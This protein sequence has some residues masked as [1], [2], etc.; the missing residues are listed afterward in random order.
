MI[1]SPPAL[2]P[3]PWS[4][5]SFLRTGAISATTLAIAGANAPLRAAVR[6]QRVRSILFANAWHCINI[7]D[8][9][10]T[11]GLLHLLETFL[12]D[13][14]VTLWPVP[15]TRPGHRRELDPAVRRMLLAGYPQLTILEAGDA[16]GKGPATRPDLVAAMRESDLFIVGSGGMHEAPLDVWRATTNKPF[17][18][19]GVTFGKISGTRAAALAKA[20][21]I[22]CRDSV[23]LANIQQAGITGPHVGFGPDTTFALHLRDEA[24]AERFL[25][26]AG[27]ANKKF[28]CVIPRHRFSPYHTIYNYPPTAQDRE[29]D[30]VNHE[31]QAADHAAAREM[32]VNWVRTTGLKVLACPEMTY[33]IALAKEQLVDPLP[34]DV[35]AKVAWR[36]SFW[37]AD[38]AASVFARALAVVSLDCHSPIIALA[39]GT[40]AI[41]LRVPTDNPHKSRMFADIGLPEWIHELDGMTGSLLTE[42][43]MEIHREPAIAAQKVERAMTFVRRRQAITMASVR[44]ALPA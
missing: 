20:A 15:S 25:D 17:G 40:P 19:N 33:G 23:S 1:K 5:R 34:A 22:Y 32:I 18:I 31:H 12:P 3:R 29:V 6:E 44:S 24:R 27:L 28:I 38:E 41:H 26:R 21:F 11:P 42:L 9:A 37:N 13:V 16:Y 10:H 36:D 30:R 39:A 8:I 14:R 35:K 2:I 43:V 4:R 7:G